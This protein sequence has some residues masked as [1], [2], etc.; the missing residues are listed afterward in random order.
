MFIKK[1]A[2]PLLLTIILLSVCGCSPRDK[3]AAMTS[4]G[5]GVQEFLIPGAA[6][7]LES[8]E[9]KNDDVP[10]IIERCYRL[11]SGKIIYAYYDIQEGTEQTPLLSLGTDVIIPD[12]PGY[13]E[14][15]FGDDRKKLVQFMKL[16]KLGQFDYKG[17][18]KRPSLSEFIFRPTA[19]WRSN[20]IL[21]LDLFDETWVLEHQR[22]SGSRLVSTD[23]VELVR[24][25]KYSE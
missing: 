8:T 13:R 16:F 11:P 9:F 7:L 10:Y 4:T 18:V 21:L 1:P 12:M 5:D 2:V 23:T 14:F 25:N 19:S 6:E 15:N 24:V 20:F 22:W 3:S 17:M